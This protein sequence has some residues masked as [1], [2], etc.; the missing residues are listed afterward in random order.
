[1]DQV[2][3]VF[4]KPIDFTIRQ[5]ETWAI[6]GNSYKS[7]FLNVLSGGFISY[8]SE[9]R[10][11][12]QSITNP[13]FRAELLKFV[14]NGSWG[15]G[16]HDASGGFTH[17]SSRYEFFKDLEVDEKVSS[18]VADMSYNSSHKYI[19]ER[20]DRLLND[21]NLKG[22]QDKFI[23]TLSNGQFRRA[24]IAKSLY[25]EPE[26]LLI[27][28]PFLGLDPFATKTVSQV[29]ERTA[30]SSDIPTTI[31]IG[32]RIQDDIPD[33]IQKVA[34][35]DESGVLFTGTK[36]SLSDT[37]ASLRDLHEKH[38]AEVES[39]INSKIQLDGN[40]SSK[41]ITEIIEMENV[42]VV[43]RGTPILKDLNWTVKSNEKWHVRGKNG[44][45]KT[46][47]LSLI[48]L[49]HPQ[50]WKR[51][52][53]INGE[54]RQSGKANYFDTNKMI[55]FTSPELHA[56]FP[57]K[58]TVKQTLSTGFVVGSYV[59]PPETELSVEQVNK[60]NHYLSL[61]DLSHMIDEQFGSLSM[62]NQKLV[63]LLRAMIN[64]PQIL[65]LDEALSAMTDE[66]ILKGK[67]LVDQWRTGCVL[68]IGHVDHEVPRCDR[69]INMN[70]AKDGVYEIGEI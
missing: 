38:Q 68:V 65:I 59:P 3:F 35:V 12:P 66:D 11:Y 53:K 31:C 6:V 54:P 50:A 69:F 26:L 48:T 41:S 33:W 17:L 20:V 32:L 21:L 55:G 40:S 51:N 62:S 30:S 43:Y 15:H 27:D 39:R 13:H 36:E 44:S 9:S 57:K 45:G 14:N 24:R 42:N 5:S 58:L 29:L 7:D 47:L 1:M 63:L 64:D 10:R 61:V 67:R 52:I 2:K 56:I 28:D 19:P 34:I 4:E 22:F 23:T 25:R 8:P 60:I 37:L 18:F 46:T 49:D 16:A 70:N